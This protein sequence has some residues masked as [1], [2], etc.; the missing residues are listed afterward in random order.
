MEKITTARGI[1]IYRSYAGHYFTSLEMMG[2][3]LTAIKLDDELKQLV[4][5]FCYSMGFKQ[6]RGTG[7]GMCMT[8]NRTFPIEQ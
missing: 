1:K 2:A 6:K 8:A 7:I 3:P 4:D 5:R